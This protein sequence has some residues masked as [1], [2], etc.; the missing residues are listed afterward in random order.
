MANVTT[1]SNQ[2]IIEFT[3]QENI[4]IDWAVEKLIEK[5]KAACGS[6]KEMM[7]R[8]SLDWFFCGLLCREGEESVKDFVNDWEY[9]PLPVRARGY[10]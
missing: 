8:E 3:P 7:S 10:C 5:Y 9:K 6:E 4:L 2:T 1:V